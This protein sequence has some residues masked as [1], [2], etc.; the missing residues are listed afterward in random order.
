MK[1]AGQQETNWRELD[2]G[3]LRRTYRSSAIMVAFVILY[4]WAY[5]YGWAVLPL[6]LGAAVNLGLLYINEVGF[7]SLIAPFANDAEGASAKQKKWLMSR[8]LGK[9]SWI[10]LVK[11]VLV[12]VVVWFLARQWTLPQ[13]AA[14]AGGFCLI[15]INIVLRVI[16]RLLIARMN[17]S[18]KETR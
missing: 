9:L 8:R 10:V 15:H 18:S 14:F 12:A 5:G 13:I 11:Y 2:D 3:F 1:G 6:F 17:E 4:V 16:S 7:G